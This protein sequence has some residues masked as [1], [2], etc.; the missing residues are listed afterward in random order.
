MAK[1]QVQANA[2]KLGLSQTLNKQ[3]GATVPSLSTA[4]PRS[5]LGAGGRPRSLLNVRARR[6]R[7]RTATSWPHWTAKTNTRACD[8]AVK[9]VRGVCVHTCA[10]AHIHIHTLLLK[11]GLLQGSST[12][13]GTGQ[14]SMNICQVKLSIRLFFLR[15]QL[16]FSFSQPPGR[17]V[18]HPCQE[19]N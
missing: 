16:H 11:H 8:S 9:H 14:S 6:P 10:H 5:P 18:S 17:A 7:H 12:C 1:L 15:P 2:N 13:P 4:A 3:N 19:R